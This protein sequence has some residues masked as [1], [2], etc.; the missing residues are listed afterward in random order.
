[1]ASK[2]AL[3]SPPC[4]G[5]R[6]RRAVRIG[7]GRSRKKGLRYSHNGSHF[8]CVVGPLSF[9]KLPYLTIIWREVKRALYEI[10]S[11]FF[12]LGLLGAFSAPLTSDEA[13]ELPEDCSLVADTTDLSEKTV[14][15]SYLEAYIQGVLDTKY[16][17]AGI[18]VSVRRGDVFLTHLPADNARADEIVLFVTALTHRSVS[19]VQKPKEEPITVPHAEEPYQVHGVW[20]PQST[21]L[22]PTQIANPRQISFSGGGRFRDRVAGKVATAVSFG[23]QFPVYRW[24]GFKGGDLQL[25]LE[26]GAFAIFDMH[27]REFPLINSDWYGGTP[28]TF[29]R[30][31]WS[32]RLRFYHI[33]SHVGDEFLE[34]HHG[35]CRKNKSFEALDVSADYRIAKNVRFYA[36]LG[37][38][39]HSDSEM[40]MKRSYFEYGFEARGPRSD[41]KQ[42]LANPFLQCTCKT[43][44]RTI[45]LLIQ[46]MLLAMSG[47]RFMGWEERCAP[48]LSIIR[49]FLLMGS[50]HAYE[51]NTLDFV[52]HTGFNP[53]A[54][55]SG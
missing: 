31:P 42:L 55:P 25:E 4:S 26:G 9:K 37:G 30:G 48:L 11:H 43:G 24:A 27:K 23:D 21:I 6:I 20:F 46:P 40:S 28:L 7:I 14:S 47:A 12:F 8:S 36:V 39:V 50:S 45:L 2:R 32:Y 33:S 3:P 1:M 29:A 41:F 52:F 13:L 54:K 34:S 44:R 53:T 17:D 18:L 22:Y 19:E 16:P 51:R 49:D 35:F 15:D 5:R 10:L 38:I